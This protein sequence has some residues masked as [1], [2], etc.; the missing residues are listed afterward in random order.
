MPKVSIQSCKPNCILSLLLRMVGSSCSPPGLWAQQRNP[1]FILKLMYLKF[2]P[3]EQKKSHLQVR[4]TK[5]QV[6]TFQLNKTEIQNRPEQIGR[7]NLSK[8]INQ[9][10]GILKICWSVFSTTGLQTESKP[11][12]TKTRLIQETRFPWT[13]ATVS[14]DCFAVAMRC[15]RVCACC[16]NDWRRTKALKARPGKYGCWTIILLG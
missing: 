9:W 1:L 14:P 8:I 11:T 5:T 4:A 2:C 10:E 3:P 13:R 6:K 7:R 12:L 15:C 16:S